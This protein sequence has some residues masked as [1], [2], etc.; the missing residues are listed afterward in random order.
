M[1]HCA[2]P[3]LLARVFAGIAATSLLSTPVFAQAQPVR[4]NA[5]I[6]SERP[7]YFDKPV[8]DDEFRLSLDQETTRRVDTLIVQL[9]DPVYKARQE[10]HEALIQ[11]GAAAMSRLRAAYHAAEDL[12]TKLRIEQVAHSAYVNHHVLDKHGFLGIS[13]RE[14]DPAVKGIKQLPIN[15]GR[16]RSNR[17]PPVLPEGRV[18][19]FV[20][21]VI[22][23]TGAHR[24]GVKPG[25]AIISMN[26][27]P[28]TGKGVAIRNAFSARIRKHKPGETVELIVVRGKETLTFTPTLTRAPQKSLGNVIVISAL[29]REATGRFQIWWEKFFLN[30]PS[31]YDSRS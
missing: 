29:Y 9:A 26:S 4:D 31:T 8:T 27:V 5:A 1:K 16:Q 3:T 12:E 15:N 7:D 28:V 18:C 20:V 22:D 11:V 25:D 24:A 14:Y 2:G 6:E 10:A 13:M 23:D 19:V 21:E 17:P 30:P